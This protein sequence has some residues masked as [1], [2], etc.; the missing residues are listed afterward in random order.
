[1]SQVE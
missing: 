1:M